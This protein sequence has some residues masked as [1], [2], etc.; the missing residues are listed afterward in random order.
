MKIIQVNANEI[1]KNVF[2]YI[3]TKFSNDSHTSAQVAPFGDDSCPVKGMKGVESATD[4]LG[5]N[6]VLGYFNRKSLAKEGEK[7]HYSLKE[8]GTESF[9]T[10]LKNDGTA[11]FGGENDHLVRYFKLDDA[12]QAFK[13]KINTELEK[14]RLALSSL[15]SVYAKTD[16]TIDISASQIVEIKTIG[17]GE[18]GGGS[19]EPTPSDQTKEDVINK[20]IDI[21]SNKTS[22]IFYASI[23][24]IYDWGTSL[25]EPKKGTDDNYVTDAQLVVIGNTSGTNTGDQVADGVTITGAGTVEDPFVATATSSGTE[26]EYDIDSVDT[27]TKYIGIAPLGTLTSAT[28]W[29]VTKLVI[30]SVGAVTETHATGIYDDRETLIYT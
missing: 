20:K 29:T 23:K 18:G 24:A 25:F 26:H 30:S 22:D 14:I 16:T 6:V 12:L 15:G 1:R 13:I 17:D 3:K 10:W 9:Y 28:G 11:E 2:R 5:Q 19:P 27:T 8:D 7:R 21:E 4:D